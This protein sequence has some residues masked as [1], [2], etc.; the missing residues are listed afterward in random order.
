ML[1]KEASINGLFAIGTKVSSAPYP[2]NTV[3]CGP[4]FTLIRAQGI[5]RLA[6]IRFNR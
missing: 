3:A 6:G 1:T 4:R 5:R 2:N